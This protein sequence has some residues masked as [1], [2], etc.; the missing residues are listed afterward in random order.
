MLT[1]LLRAGAIACAL[2]LPFAAPAAAQDSPTAYETVTATLG[3]GQTIAGGCESLEAGNLYEVYRDGGCED[4]TLAANGLTH[5]AAKG[6][7]PTRVVAWHPSKEGYAAYAKQFQG[8]ADAAPLPVRAPPAVVERTVRVEVPV[9]TIPLAVQF[10]VAALGL[11][12]I[13]CAI[14]IATRTQE[15][16]EAL[17]ALRKERA[18]PRRALTPAYAP[19][20][21]ADDPEVARLL[22]ALDAVTAAPEPDPKELDRT[23]DALI[24][25]GRIERTRLA[26][27]VLRQECVPDAKTPAER[28]IEVERA[29]LERA[30]HPPMAFRRLPWE[31]W[32]IGADEKA[33]ERSIF[34]SRYQAARHLK[35]KVVFREEGAKKRTTRFD[36]LFEPAPAS[37]SLATRGTERP[38]TV[39]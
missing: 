14:L 7:S 36:E 33:I 27:K 22:A 25:R 4:R 37:E 11:A 30:G 34:R 10:V 17:E 13:A 1:P 20:P 8:R 12:L 24:E 21:P 28:T 23:V 31:G 26:R 18:R 3:H 15:R 16:N 38:E 39:H 29:L 9:E 35:K 6:L 5:E 19:P 32:R 2:G